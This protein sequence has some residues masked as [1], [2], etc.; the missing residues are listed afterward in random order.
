MKYYFFRDIEH[1]DNLF[2]GKTYNATGIVDKIF[3]SRENKTGDKDL[4]VSYIHPFELRTISVWRTYSEVELFE[5]TEWEWE[6][7]K[8]NL[9]NF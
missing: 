5:V 2:D 6:E 7:L 1:R 8:S 3:N 9:N 4:S